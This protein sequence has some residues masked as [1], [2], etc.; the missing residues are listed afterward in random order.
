MNRTENY[1][2]PQF[3]PTDTYKLEDYN[4]AYRTIDEKL[5]EANDKG[6]SFNDFKNNGGDIHGVLY[7]DDVG[8]IGNDGYNG[9]EVVN[10]QG[11]KK[12]RL[13]SKDNLNNYIAVE[14]DGNDGAFKPNTNGVTNLGTHDNKFNNLYLKNDAITLR[15]MS[16]EF[17]ISKD[18]IAEFAINQ[19]DGVMKVHAYQNGTWHSNPVK[20][21]KRGDV[22]FGGHNIASSGYSKLPN[23]MLLQW[24]RLE[25]TVVPRGTHTIVVTLPVMFSTE[26]LFCCGN[27]NFNILKGTDAYIE[28]LNVSVQRLNRD[29]VVVKVMDVG[30]LD[31]ESTFEIFW[32]AIGY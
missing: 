5:K 30:N 22:Y 19:E 17:D 3:E 32:M 15:T 13:V 10:P 20:I 1:N 14:F 12:V 21:E 24:G 25:Q 26:I 31:V 8:Y 27:A 16:N 2:L 29:K 4:E 18:G 7:V 9:I 11:G 6:D 23:T 28:H